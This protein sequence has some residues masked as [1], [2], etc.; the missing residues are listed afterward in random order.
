MQAVGVM[1]QALA[2][3][4]EDMRA[5]LGGCQLAFVQELAAKQEYRSRVQVCCS[6]CSPCI[7]QTEVQD[8]HVQLYV[9]HT[10]TVQDT[11]L[12]SQG[13]ADMGKPS[14]DLWSEAEQPVLAGQLV[15][16]RSSAA[17]LN[18]LVLLMTYD[19]HSADDTMYS[20]R[21][22]SAQASVMML[23]GINFLGL[24]LF[25][26]FPLLSPLCF[27]T[28]THNHQGLQADLPRMNT[29]TVNLSILTHHGQV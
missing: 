24:F 17:R 18:T 2:V 6:S 28:C 27:C 20:T 3:K 1:V 15:W 21:A 9:K 4:V 7:L 16:L 22:A 25:T 26:F 29:V 10:E 14:T 23:I 12:S 19:M 11:S 13:S 8:R 5:Q